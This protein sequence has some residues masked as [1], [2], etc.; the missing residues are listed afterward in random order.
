[1]LIA[2][3][4]A[5]PAILAIVLTSI[6]QKKRKYSIN[7]S[8]I[9]LTMVAVIILI[10]IIATGWYINELTNGRVMRLISDNF[11]KIRATKSGE[12]YM[13][14]LSGGRMTIWANAIEIWQENKIFGSGLGTDVPIRSKTIAHI[15]N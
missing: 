4:L 7:T 1:P 5:I 14:D 8:T 12:L 10:G 6:T 9:K 2:Y 11:L 15:H 3:M 13:G